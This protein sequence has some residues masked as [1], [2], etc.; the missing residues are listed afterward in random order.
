MSKFDQ[1]KK[2]SRSYDEKWE[3]YENDFNY[4]R[5]WLLRE[6]TSF[7]EC[8]TKNF[9]F[10]RLTQE[11]DYFSDPQDK[12]ML[13]AKCIEHKPIQGYRLYDNGFWLFYIDL[14]LDDARKDSVR[15]SFKVKKVK[16]V[17]KAFHQEFFEVKENSDEDMRNFVSHIYQSIFDHFENGFD[18]FV[19]GEKPPLG[20]IT[21]QTEA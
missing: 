8:P 9:H 11:S 20:F 13:G 5:K 21:R 19:R 6:L 12:F 3:A 15:L 4:F 18:N 16:D 2:A 10:P 14:Y 1:L 7:L 17:F